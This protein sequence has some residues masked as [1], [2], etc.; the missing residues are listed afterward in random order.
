MSC[1]PRWFTRSLE[2]RFWEKVVVHDDAC[3]EWTGGI[4]PS[5]YGSIHAPRKGRKARN[6]YAT[7]VSWFIHYG[8]WPENMLLHSCDNPPCCNPGH[9]TEGDHAENARQKMERGRHKQKNQTHCFKGHPYSVENTYLYRNKRGCRLCRRAA[10]QRFDQ[11]RR[12]L[13]KSCL[14][15]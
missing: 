5:G 9:L 1:R 7:H 4:T 15:G 3:W 13:T 12:Q 10:A 14:E 6:C 2:E 8:K 11:Q